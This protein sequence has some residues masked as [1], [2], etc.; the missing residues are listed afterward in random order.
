VRRPVT[1]QTEVTMTG[2]PPSGV[3]GEV[4]NHPVSVIRIANRTA[5][6]ALAPLIQSQHD[7]PPE[8]QM[9]CEAW[10]GPE[11]CPRS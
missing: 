10:R 2:S 4:R 9:I 8:V 7:R 6:G 1:L 11:T 3:P 5:S